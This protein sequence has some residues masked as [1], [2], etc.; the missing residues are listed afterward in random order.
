MTLGLFLAIFVFSVIVLVSNRASVSSATQFA[1]VASVSTL[2]ALTVTTVFGFVADLHGVMRLMRVQHLLETIATESLAAIEEN[3]PPAF[4]YV[5]AEPPLADPSPRRLCYTGPA[6][7][8]WLPTWAAWSIV[9]AEPVLVEL[10]VGVGE[11]LADG[12]LVALAHGGDLREGDVTRFSSSAARRTFM[13]DPAFGFWQLA[14]V[15]IGALSLA[16][17]YPTTGVQAIDLI[18]DLLAITGSRPDPT[19]LRVD[20]SGTVRVKRKLRN[21]DALLALARLR[22]SLRCRRAAGGPAA[23]RDVRRTRVHASR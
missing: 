18:S 2:L 17:N 9:S 7:S 8:S 23:A 3:F 4:A 13:Q 12:T 10:T 22:S 21:F 11:Y 20:A 19:G 15:A 1:P 16:V 6:G 14:D 5:Y